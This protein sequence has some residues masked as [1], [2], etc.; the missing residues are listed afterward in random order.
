MKK[1]G[2]YDVPF[3]RNGNQ[4]HYPEGQWVDGQ[5]AQCRMFPNHPFEDTLTFDSYSRGRSAAYFHMTRS[6]GTGVVVFMTDFCDM[7]PHL[8]NGKI[9]GRFQHIKRGANYGTTLLEAAA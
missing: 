1:I 3:D 5:Y 6:D 8:V 9:T 7:V 2:A 4:L